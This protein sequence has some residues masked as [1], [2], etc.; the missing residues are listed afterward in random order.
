MTIEEKIL[1]IDNLRIAFKIAINSNYSN[2]KEI[3][4]LYDKLY[5]MRIEKVNLLCKKERRDKLIQINSK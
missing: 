5:H 3:G 1:Q 4:D 2:S